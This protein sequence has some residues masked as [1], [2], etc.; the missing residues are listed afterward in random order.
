MARKP[1]AKPAM[2]APAALQ[3]LDT[4]VPG[5]NDVLGGGVS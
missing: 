3:L 5:L 4:G 2:R 1:A